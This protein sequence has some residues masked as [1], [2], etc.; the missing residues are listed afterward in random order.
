MATSKGGKP[1]PL[2]AFWDA[3]SGTS[4][5]SGS[6][7]DLLS[8][9]PGSSPL[10]KAAKKERPAQG[11]EAKGDPIF[12]LLRALYASEG[13]QLNVVLIMRQTGFGPTECFE[14]AEKA[15]KLGFVS[16]TTKGTDTI[17]QLTDVGVG[18]ARGA[19]A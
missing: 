3:Y 8:S 17:Y 18:V 10:K 13:H 6:M 16:R 4:N 7:S 14:V 1:G 12:T 19:P 15:E 9:V 5:T 2:D 11:E